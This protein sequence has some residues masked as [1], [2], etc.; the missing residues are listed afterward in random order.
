MKT[1]LPWMGNVVDRA[2]GTAQCTR[3]KHTSL[4]TPRV[5]ARLDCEPLGESIDATGARLPES[6]ALTSL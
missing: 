6:Q 5:D 4:G 2:I 3:D 1:F